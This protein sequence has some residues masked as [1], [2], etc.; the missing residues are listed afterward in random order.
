VLSALSLRSQEATRGD[1]AK[2]DPTGYNHVG[3][4]ETGGV[5]NKV[6]Y[7]GARPVTPESCFTFC[8]DQADKQSP[9]TKAVDSLQ[10]F[11]V[12]GDTSGSRSRKCWCAVGYTGPKVDGCGPCPKALHGNAESGSWESGGDQ[13]GGEG[14]S[15]V[16]LF[17]SC[18]HGPEEEAKVK[19]EETLKKV[20]AEQETRKLFNVLREKQPCGKVHA[21]SVNGASTLVGS[22]DECKLACGSEKRCGMF[23]YDADMGRCLF[24]DDTDTEVERSPAMT[25]YIKTFGKGPVTV[26]ELIGPKEDVPPEVEKEQQKVL[27][28]FAGKFDHKPTCPDTC[29]G[30]QGNVRA[31]M[32]KN[33]ACMACAANLRTPNCEPLACPLTC[34]GGAGNVKV[35]AC[36][37]YFCKTEACADKRQNCK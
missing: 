36:D 5:L 24:T 31:R 3:C 22:L 23:T 9:L 17:H 32:C 4:F 14:K 25:C 37:D 13:C 15:S 1:L 16:F 7:E 29:L 34:L 8:A 21:V 20:A 27:A 6:E 10:Y 33:P 30:G 2:V 28:P 19:A 26:R 11:A 12:E 18:A 35:Q